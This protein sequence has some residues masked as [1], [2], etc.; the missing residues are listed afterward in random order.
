MVSQANA[1]FIQG[2]GD[3]VLAVVF[4][5]LLIFTLLIITCIKFKMY[6]FFNYPLSSV[7]SV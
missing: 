7:H 6:A 2:D 1:F 4:V 5:Y 3:Y